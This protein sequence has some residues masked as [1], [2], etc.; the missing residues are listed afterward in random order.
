MKRSAR[1]IVTRECP[2]ACPDCCN[3]FGINPTPLYDLHDLRGYESIIIT[4]GEPLAHPG[5]TRAF[6]NV[7]RDIEN[8]NDEL[9][10]KLYVYTAHPDVE[11][12][13]EFLGL[14]DGLTFTLHYEATDAD[15]IGLK[16]FCDDQVPYV[17]DGLSLRLFIDKRLYDRYDLSNIDMRGW[18]VVRKLEWQPEGCP[19][20]DNE[21]LF[22]W[23]P[24]GITEH[25]IDIANGRD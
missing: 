11:L 18:D 12:L 7:L 9:Y 24:E 16:K 20:P 14:T 8:E 10:G 17:I 21:D 25:F 2:R 4:G 3:S 5:R 22:E 13:H 15:I 1:V 6:I 23:H 19:V